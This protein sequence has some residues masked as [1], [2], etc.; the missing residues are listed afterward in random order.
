MGG[1]LSGV[2]RRTECKG[3]VS[4]ERESALGGRGGFYR[5]LEKEGGGS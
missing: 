1:G 3:E 2:S 5:I 4:M